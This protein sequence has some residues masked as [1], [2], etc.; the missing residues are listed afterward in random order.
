MLFSAGSE[1]RLGEEEGVGNTGLA[2]QFDEVELEE[3]EMKGW[4]C[5]EDLMGLRKQ[6]VVSDEIRR[7][8]E[9]GWR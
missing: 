6:G 7:R 9:S 1:F 2:D 8:E 5:V 3:V 4:V